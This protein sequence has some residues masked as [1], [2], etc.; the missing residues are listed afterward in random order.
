[1]ARFA[2]PPY[3]IS[4]GEPYPSGANPVRNGVN[5]SLFSQ[6][7][8]AVELLLFHRFDDPGPF[9]IISFHP[10]LNKTFHYWHIFVEG[11]GHGQI[12]AY[13]VNGPNDPTAG[14]RFNHSK[15]LIDPYSRG[16]VYGRNWSRQRA[17]HLDDNCETSMKSLVVNA[18][19]YDWE[20]VDP[21][22]RH[23]SNCII[24]EMHVRGFT[25][26]P[27]SG[28]T[29][30]GT[31]HALVEKIPY[32]KELGI[33]T[34]ELMPIHQFDSTEGAGVNPETGERLTN[35]WG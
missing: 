3:K 28:V 33:T 35:Y 15:V 24:Y 5:F 19:V 8:T 16:V 23:L 7:A 4:D 1:M 2:S 17:C 21:P 20:S 18:D 25:R 32:L 9:Q 14:M 12:Y 26:H 22:D 31:F 6:H 27:S 30:P 29:H 13:R 11:V 34:V 10:V